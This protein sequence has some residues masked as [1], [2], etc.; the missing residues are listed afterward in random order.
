LLR[1]AIAI[2]TAAAILIPVGA[3]GRAQAEGFDQGRQD[4]TVFTI[5]MRTLTREYPGIYLSGHY[6]VPEYFLEDK[7]PGRTG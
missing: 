6:D 3:A 5:E 4:T 7:A 1:G 2:A